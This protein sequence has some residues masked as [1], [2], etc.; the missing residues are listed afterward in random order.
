[1]ITACVESRPPPGTMRK[2]AAPILRATAPR[3]RAMPGPGR[4]DHR[5]A[6]DGAEAGIGLW[7][8]PADAGPA[9]DAARQAR[10][11]APCGAP[12]AFRPHETPLIADDAAGDAVTHHAAA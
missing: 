12:P 2:P 1:M 7:R 3:T 9:A 5:F 10:I 4:R 11:S 8:A 6:A